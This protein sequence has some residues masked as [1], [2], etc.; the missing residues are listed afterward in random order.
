MPGFDKCKIENIS[1][2]EMKLLD[3]FECSICLG[4]LNEPMS[5]QCCRTLYCLQCIHQWLAVNT[6]C[7]VDRKPL[8]IQQLCKPNLLVTNIL[9]KFEISCDFSKNGCNQKLKLSNAKR[10]ISV[11][12]YNPLHRRST[13]V[14]GSGSKLSHKLENVRNFL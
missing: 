6:C 13:C 11:C 8:K 9:S 1:S 7:P 2:D 3:E 10:H 12:S 5:T 4:I 14:A